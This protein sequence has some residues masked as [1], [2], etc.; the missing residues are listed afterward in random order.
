MIFMCRLSNRYRSITCLS[1]MD[2]FSKLKWRTY[3]H[4]FI[5][6]NDQSV[7]IKW[8]LVVVD[9]SRILYK[10][11]KWPVLYDKCI[12]KSVVVCNLYTYVIQM[13]PFSLLL[14]S[15]FFFFGWGSF[16][17]FSLCFVCYCCCCCFGYFLLFCFLKSYL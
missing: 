9:D 16:V 2:K 3:V 8:L 4:I 6:K 5:V 15:L 10:A 14:F 13:L 7:P 11:S 17:L 12:G 1:E